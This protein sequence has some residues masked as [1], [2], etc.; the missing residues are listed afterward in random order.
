M[1]EMIEIKHKKKYSVWKIDQKFKQ[2]KGKLKYPIKNMQHRKLFINSL[3]PHFKY[4]SRKK[5]FQ[6]QAKAL[7]EALQ[8]EENQYKL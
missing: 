1:N 3:F 7:Q 5:K 6:T 2:L 4:P 8:L